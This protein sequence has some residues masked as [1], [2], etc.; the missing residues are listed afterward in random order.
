MMDSQLLKPKA[1][2]VLAFVFVNLVIFHE[3]IG[4]LSVFSI[5]YIQDAILALA[6]ANY[7]RQNRGNQFVTKLQLK[8]LAVAL[9]LKVIGDVLLPIR[10]ESIS[11]MPYLTVIIPHAGMLL[12]LTGINIFQIDQS[13]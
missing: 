8:L 2:A 4:W 12:V 5:V 6:L 13:L 11:N 3:R 9:G 1:H 10:L 7:I